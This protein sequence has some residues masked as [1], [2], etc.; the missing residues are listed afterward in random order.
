MRSRGDDDG[1][2]ANDDDGTP[3]NKRLTPCVRRTGGRVD[4]TH[5]SGAPACFMKNR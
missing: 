2:P 1:T 4:E 3:A 5:E